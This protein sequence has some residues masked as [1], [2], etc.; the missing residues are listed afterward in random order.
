[1]MEPTELYRL[2]LPPVPT[3][4]IIIWLVIAAV[5]T[6]IDPA[7]GRVVPVANGIR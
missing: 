4:T 2:I 5:S 6:L 3:G 1:L 7:V